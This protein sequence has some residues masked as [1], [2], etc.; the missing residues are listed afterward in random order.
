MAN[1]KLRARRFWRALSNA[2]KYDADTFIL[3]H[4]NPSPARG[5]FRDYL[6]IA[7]PVSRPAAVT[8]LA[9]F[10]SLERHESLEP[11]IPETVLPFWLQGRD[12]RT[13]QV[14]L[15]PP[16]WRICAK[17][18]SASKPE[19]RIMPHSERV[20]MPVAAATTGTYS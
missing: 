3:A 1:I 2:I 10:R 12:D 18:N 15:A 17:P 5:Y 19:S 13:G 7:A 16:R 14:G 11:L 6:W 4:I 8:M 9:G 20:G